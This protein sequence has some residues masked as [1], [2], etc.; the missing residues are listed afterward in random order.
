MLKV[1]IKQ[2]IQDW[3]GREAELSALETEAREY[4]KA[5]ALKNKLEQRQGKNIGEE[6]L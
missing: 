6:S 2:I 4:D 1:N 5:E 3:H